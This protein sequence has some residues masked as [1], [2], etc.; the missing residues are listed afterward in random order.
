MNARGKIKFAGN[1]ILAK[2]TELINYLV[3]KLRQVLNFTK[4]TRL[5]QV[6]HQIP[7]PLS[8]ISTPLQ[9]VGRPLL[10]TGVRKRLGG[11]I[12]SPVSFR[13][14]RIYSAVSFRRGIGP[15]VSLCLQ[16]TVGGQRVVLLWAVA[17]RP[18]VV[19]VA[20]FSPGAAFGWSVAVLV[21][22][23]GAS[24]RP[25][26]ALQGTVE[27]RIVVSPAVKRTAGRSVAVPRVP[28][29]LH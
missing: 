24:P 16:L 10:G 20:A 5:L 13:S 15:S 21:H 8:V 14:G 4:I 2:Q 27:E 25:G 19:T 12:S 29:L 6:T 28:P 9:G 22:P 3:L 1:E 7:A 18:A 26:L 11:R 17:R 23:G